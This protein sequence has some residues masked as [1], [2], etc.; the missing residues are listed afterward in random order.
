MVAID[1]QDRMY[2]IGHHDERVDMDIFVVNVKSLHLRLSDTT[3]HRDLHFTCYNFTEDARAV[4]RADGHEI[5]A[6]R[7]V[8][9]VSKTSRFDAVFVLV[10]GHGELARWF[11]LAR[12][13]PLSRALLVVRETLQATSLRM[14]LFWN[15]GL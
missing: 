7:A 4:Q 1:H 14:V 2:M 8:I 11:M 3:L 10:E 15:R 12:V 13:V 9:P 6:A 5:P